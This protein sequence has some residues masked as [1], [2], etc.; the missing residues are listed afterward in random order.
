MAADPAISGQHSETPVR[1]VAV[2]ANLRLNFGLNPPA[3]FEAMLIHSF[4]FGGMVPE[5]FQIWVSQ[6]MAS[7]HTMVLSTYVI[8]LGIEVLQGVTAKSPGYF[9][10]QNLDLINAHDFRAVIWQVNI[11]KIEGLNLLMKALKQR[12]GIEALVG[13]G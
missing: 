10:L 11:P 3:G 8:A 13:K 6:Q 7:F 9:A 2:A 4:S 1:V 12:F 5:T